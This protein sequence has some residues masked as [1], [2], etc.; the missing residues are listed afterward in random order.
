MH[1]MA[2]YVAVIEHR[3]YWQNPIGSKMIRKFLPSEMALEVANNLRQHVVLL[4][5]VYSTLPATSPEWK[6][7]LRHPADCPHKTSTLIYD[8]WQLAYITWGISPT[9]SDPDWNFKKCLEKSYQGKVFCKRTHKNHNSFTHQII[10]FFICCL[11]YQQTLKNNFKR[12]SV[13]N[14]KNMMTCRRSLQQP[15]KDEG[16]KVTLEPCLPTTMLCFMMILYR[17]Y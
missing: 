12:P 4:L 1:V 6:N 11:Y 17:K 8:V 14:N 7:P 3:R 2:G 5:M 13:W 9:H 10:S 16:L 15:V